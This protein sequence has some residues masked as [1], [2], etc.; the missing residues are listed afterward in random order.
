MP[1]AGLK[2]A[3]SFFCGPLEVIW[4][5]LVGLLNIFRAST[6]LSYSAPRVFSSSRQ[7]W[8]C[9]HGE[10]RGARAKPNCAKEQ[11][12][13]NECFQA[14]ACL[15]FANI[16]LAKVRVGGD[17]KDAGQ[18]R[19]NSGK[20]FYLCNQSNANAINDFLLHFV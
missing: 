19:V 20:P 14:S 16:P 12:R 5:I 4:W 6:E 11:V 2:V 8:A 7:S 1:Y 10:S 17:Y 13:T 9:F 3:H 18:N 15:T